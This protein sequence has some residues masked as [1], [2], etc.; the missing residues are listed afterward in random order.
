MPPDAGEAD[1]E[2][3][4]LRAEI[5]RLS[6]SLGGPARMDTPVAGDFLLPVCLPRHRGAVERD[7]GEHSPR[8][9]PH[10]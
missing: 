8:I 4:Y 7:S 3:D 9:L 6:L 2:P 10:T 1:L 5:D